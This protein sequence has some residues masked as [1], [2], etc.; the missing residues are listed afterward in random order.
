[1]D[2]IERAA[3]VFDKLIV[4]VMFNARK[5]YLFSPTERVALLTRSTAHLPNVSVMYSEKLLAELCRELGVVVTVRGLRAV[6][7]FEHEFQMA[8]IN[9]NLNPEMET[10]FLTA[11]ERHQY[12]SSSVVKEVGA[13][14]G[15]ISA[16]VPAPV[17]A[18]I[19]NKLLT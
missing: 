8:L 1:L 19:K 17:L 16:F 12:L 2:I 3:S 7:D 18:E 15:D 5:Q 9:R 4:A 11:K 10:V 14:G 13:L 6:T